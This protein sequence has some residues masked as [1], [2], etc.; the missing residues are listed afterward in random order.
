MP[1]IIVA[2]L[3]LLL[4]VVYVLVAHR[5]GNEMKPNFKTM[6]IMGVIWIPAGIAIGSPYLWGM[7]IVFAVIGLL[8]KSQWRD[9][10]KWS[11][12]SPAERKTRSILIG[13][14]TLLLVVGVATFFII[15]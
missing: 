12:L 9:E 8:K 13:G 10:R 7:G 1:Y 5:R 2:G 14:A 15:E 4:L 6:F 3:I 11:D